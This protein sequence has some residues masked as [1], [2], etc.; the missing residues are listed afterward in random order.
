MWEEIIVKKLCQ[1][2]LM[3][4]TAE[5]CTG[6]LLA[7]QLLNVAGASAIFSE[8]Y[9]TYSNEAKERILG[10][11]HEILEQYGAVSC[12]TAQAMALGAARLAHADIALST[13]G[14]A[15]PSGGTKEKPVGLVYIGCVI[16]G[17]TYVKEC[18]FT[19]TRDRNRKD[20]VVSA[21]ELLGN[22]L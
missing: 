16:N 19:G 8:G 1:Q 3:I 17:N 22:Y 7:G 6:G 9:I 18:Y 13:T 12:Q 20:A 2:N 4:T 21:L 14:I 15:G 10:V 5:S 11:S